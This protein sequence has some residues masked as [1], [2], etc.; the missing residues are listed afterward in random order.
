MYTLDKLLNFGVLRMQDDLR[1]NHLPV[2]S[3]VA[4]VQIFKVLRVLPVCKLDLLEVEGDLVEAFLLSRLACFP[5]IGD[6]LE[7]G[8]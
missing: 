3:G 6:D 2:E 4:V 5:E 7:L 1:R 8:M